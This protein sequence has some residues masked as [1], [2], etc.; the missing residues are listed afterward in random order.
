[1]D[2]TVDAPPFPWQLFHNLTFRCC[3]DHAKAQSPKEFEDLKA[4]I[5]DLENLV[6]LVQ[7]QEEIDRVKRLLNHLTGLNEATMGMRRLIAMIV[8]EAKEL[9][10]LVDGERAG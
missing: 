2:N 8:G 5:K 7:H 3:T 9:E 6:V 10:A 1:M 4:Q